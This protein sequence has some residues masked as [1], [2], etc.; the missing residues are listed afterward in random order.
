MEFDLEK[1]GFGIC[2]KGKNGMPDRPVLYQ[3]EVSFA[4]TD[5]EQYWSDAVYW[6][7]KAALQNEPLAVQMLQCAA[8]RR[9][10]AP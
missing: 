8:I 5:M 9:R 1:R 2:R 10:S 3:E 7:K 6:Y 4:G